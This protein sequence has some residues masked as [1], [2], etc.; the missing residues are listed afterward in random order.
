MG[1]LS[2]PDLPPGPHRD[3]VDALHDLHHRAGWPSLRALA[4]E[5]GC[6]PTTVSAVFTSPRLPTWGVLELV[7]EAMGGE[8]GGFHALW[9]AATTPD[10][11]AV[12]AATSVPIAG[13]RAELAV[14]HRHLMDGRGLL[15]VMGEAGIGKSRLVSA[16]AGDAGPAYVATATCL[17]LSVDVPLLPVVDA[18]RSVH[19]LDGGRWLREA[20]AACPP[21]VP[22]ALSRLLPEIEPLV[23]GA[24]D[25]DDEWALQHLFAAVVATLN[26]LA[27]SRRLALLVED[28][29]WADS[30]TLDL[31]EHVLARGTDVPVVGTWRL[32]DPA[33][34]VATSEWFVRVRRLPAVTTLVLGPL[35]L[36]ET[37]EQLALLAARP[38]TADRVASIHRRSEGQPLFTEQLAA[39]DDGQDLPRLLGDLLD[40]RIE[41]LGGPAWAVARALGVADRS[42]TDAQLSGV[43]ELPAAELATGLHELADRQLLGPTVGH[44]V[45]LRHPLLAEA[46]RRRLLPH[47][48]AEEHRRIAT[49][50]AAAPDGSPAEIATH[51]QRAEDPG[52]EIVWR[53]RAAREAGQRFAFTQEAEQWRRVLDL[54]P[55]GVHTLVSPRVRRWDAYLAAMDALEFIDVAAARVVAEEAM[56]ELPDPESTDAAEVYRRAAQFQGNQGDPEGAL[57]LLDKAIEIYEALP[58]S[59]GYVRALD[60]R[61][62]V[63]ASLGRD[64]EGAATNAR[65]MEVGAALGD[66][67]GQRTR[68]S[69]QAVYEAMAGE[70]GR[71]RE[72]IEEA[73]AMEPPEPD[74][75]GTIYVAVNHTIILLMASA[76]PDEVAAA[77]RPGLEAATAWE[78]DTWPLSALRNNMARAMRL[79]GQVERAAELVDPLTEGEPTHLRS[80]DHD[81]RAHLDLLR[82]RLAEATH[83]FELA[84]A[85]PTDGLY[86]RIE[87]VEHLVEADLWCG[88]ARAAFDRAVPTVREAVATTAA[89]Y[90]GALL[91]LAARAAADLAGDGATPA[92]RR[93]L[94]DELDELLARAVADPLAPHPAIVCRP[95]LAAAWAAERA[96]LAG[97]ESVDLWVTAAREWDRLTRPHDAAYCR[98]RAAEVALATGEGTVAQRLLARATRDAREHVP[99]LEAIR[100]TLLDRTPPRDQS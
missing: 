60:A 79:A 5:V 82:G 90:A 3:L 96:R 54:W 66:A 93:A 92:T 67:A 15:L 100:A 94:L 35:S 9:L 12:P 73:V 42:L 47:E 88:R 31:L 38:V 77:A 18:L 98:W 39:Q 53:I 20:L 55:A 14:V 33:T 80:G 34:P 17:P 16:A 50:L 71:A 76:G 51:W 48:Q 23:G 7:V 27:S 36:E 26:A 2:R 62:Y 30:T 61:E 1:A 21:Y 13:R 58:P 83:R 56:R 24:P 29:H 89:T 68:L 74:P 6:S 28:L 25:P 63:L 43:A 52:R 45:V 85:I 41:G 59:P 4:R 10:A 40:R 72:L 65:A 86:N 87:V 44:A 19:D 75:S 46:V 99:L 32:D 91:V 8:V 70:V 11:A 78:L 84:A 69:V 22:L 97:R 49:V 64:A 81:E 57:S 37:A 95:A